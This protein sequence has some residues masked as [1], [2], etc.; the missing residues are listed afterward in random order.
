MNPVPRFDPADPYPDSDGAPMA[1][2]TLQFDWIVKI[3]ENLEILFAD[4][5]DVFVAGDLFW[6]PVQDRRLANPMAPDAMVVFGRPKGPRGSYKQWEEDGIAPQVVFEVQSPSNGPKELRDKLEFY[7]THGAAE[8]Y[9]YDPERNRLEVWL[10]QDGRLAPVAYVNGWT[11]PRLGIRFALRAETLEIFD[12]A[13]RPFLSPVE[14]ARRA[15]QAEKQAREAEEQAREAAARAAQE[16][17]LAAQEHARAEQE[18]ARAEQ[19]DA[20]AEQER[21]CAEQERALAGQERARAERLAERLRAL[22]IDPDA[23]G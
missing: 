10:R 19:A 21:I 17:A 23:V 15:R 3:K 8:Y 11:S 4:R 5:P 14:L 13:G 18:R 20:R 6:Y 7:D 16:R 22:G 1:E 2:N 12:P 9:L